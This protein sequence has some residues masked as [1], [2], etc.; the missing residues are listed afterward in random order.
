L[1]GKAQACGE[2]E[3]GDLFL[4]VSWVLPT[5]DGEGLGPCL[6]RSRVFAFMPKK[7]IG[8]FGFGGFSAQKRLSAFCPILMVKKGVV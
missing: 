5:Q 1:P 8:F 4:P 6:L 7:R 3:P 2:A